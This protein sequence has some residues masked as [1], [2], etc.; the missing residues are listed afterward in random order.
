MKAP[1]APTEAIGSA[2]AAEFHRRLVL[3][4]REVCVYLDRARERLSATGIDLPFTG[5]RFPLTPAV[6]PA[7]SGRQL[8]R[9]CRAI[10]NGIET[11]FRETFEGDVARLA[12]YLRL[13]PEEQ[14]LY[15][16]S[17]T[18]QDWAAVARPDFFATGGRHAIIETN[19]TTSIG[20]LVDGD[21]LRRI[22]MGMPV[23]REI[24]AEYRLRSPD[25]IAGLIRVLRTEVPDIDRRS[26]AIVDWQS[27]FPVWTYYYRA[28]AERFRRSGISAQ[29]VPLESLEVRDSGVFAGDSRVDVVY[30]FFT[31]TRF[32]QPEVYARH[33]PLLEAMGNGHLRLIGGF[34]HKL[35]TPKM[36]LA[37]LSDEQYQEQFP[38]AMRR[39]LDLVI[40]WTRVVADRRTL[41]RG[42]WVDLLE[43]ARAHR[44][45]FVLKPNLGYGG[46]GVT[47]GSE[48]PA[49]EWNE[50][51]EQALMSEDYWLLQERV[52]NEPVELA[53]VVDHEIE[54][55]PVR[56]DYGVFML[57]RRFSGIARRNTT[58]ASGTHLTNLSRGGGLGF[59]FFQAG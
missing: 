4:K 29:P 38:A 18:D 20:L 14:A 55:R 36:F 24:I 2:L 16:L 19:I 51:I 33:R 27:E 40:P 43:L 11:L 30:R 21:L 44:E 28:L 23:C 31:T 54:F 26:V 47:L 50:R 58:V 56:V 57:G 3:R 46:Y 12:G 8:G 7:D 41:F 48:V 34:S 45:E 6:L 42:A 10:F 53:F 32:R 15:A 37:L 1:M 39:A 5:D 17:S 22:A 52:P 13:T 59:V 49:S 35:F 9:G 25:P